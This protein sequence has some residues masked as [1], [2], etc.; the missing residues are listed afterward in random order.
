MKKFKQKVAVVTGAG[1]GIGR[2]ICVE[3]ARRGSHLALVDINPEA[4]KGTQEAVAGFGVNASAHT[5]DI[6]DKNAMAKLADDV[7]NEHGKINLL[8]NNAGITLQKN[9]ASHSLEDWERVVGI[10]LWG[11]I[12]GIHFFLP[13]LQESGK[14]EWAHIVNLSSI[15]GFMG[16]PSQSSYAATKGAVK[17]LSEALNAEF[18][19]YNIGVTSIHPG[20]VKT[21][22]MLAT[23]KES[24]DVDSAKRN[25]DM[26]MKIGI[27]PD[28]AAKIIISAVEKNKL[29][30][31]VGTDAVVLDV[32]KRWM[33][34]FLHTPIKMATTRSA[35]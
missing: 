32:L 14:N 23:M 10:N 7:I 13:H 20:A 9:F 19:Q 22:M 12:Y 16:M 8:V 27:E 3:L 21:D 26:A 29:R 11:V 33:P 28:K 25:F 17:N 1:G 5:T 24:E 35:K 18:D 6:T 4:I 30:Q 2:A 15:A 31:R 34:E